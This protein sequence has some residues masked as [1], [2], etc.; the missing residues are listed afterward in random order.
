MSVNATEVT[1]RQDS[2]HSAYCDAALQAE[3]VYSHHDLGLS[4]KAG[5]YCSEYDVHAVKDL[6]DE[7]RRNRADRAPWKPAG[8]I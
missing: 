4:K 7:R 1:S 8:Q 2:G 3:S 6:E 5:P